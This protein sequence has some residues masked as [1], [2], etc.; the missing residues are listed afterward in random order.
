[1]KSNVCC[2]ASTDALEK[3]GARPFDIAAAACFWFAPVSHGALCERSLLQQLPG[4]LAP[5]QEFF[6]LQFLLLRLRLGGKLCASYIHIVTAGCRVV[7]CV[8][9]QTTTAAGQ[10]GVHC[11]TRHGIALWPCLPVRCRRFV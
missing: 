6:E 5:W 7:V 1:M 9:W 3:R 11:A 4:K 2:T 8:S 10:K